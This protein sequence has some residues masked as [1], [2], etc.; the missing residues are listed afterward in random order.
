MAGCSSPSPEAKAKKLIKDHLFKTLNNFDS[1][2]VVEFGKLDSAF[3][4][5]GDDRQYTEWLE[6]FDSFLEISK[7]NNEKAS[8]Y[9]TYGSLLNL[10]L[11]RSR[12]ASDSMD[13][14]LKKADSILN[15]FKPVFKGWKMSH[16]F[17]AKNLEG[18]LGIHHRLYYFNLSIDTLTGH[19]DIGE[20]DDG[21]HETH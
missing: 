9:I 15:V 6:K 17:R 21:K 1:Y 16:S 7:E 4:D 8:R 14:C 5:V 11:K 3:T 13:I 19:K 2:K 18:N 12:E 20:A 10:Y